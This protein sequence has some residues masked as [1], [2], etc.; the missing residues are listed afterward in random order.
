MKIL[1]EKVEKGPE[2]PVIDIICYILLTYYSVVMNRANSQ[3]ISD[4]KKRSSEFENY[5]PKVG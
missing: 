4:S 5:E 3:R 2:R 1:A